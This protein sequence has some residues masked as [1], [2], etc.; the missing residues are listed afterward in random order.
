[1]ETGIVRH[2]STAQQPNSHIKEGNA[3]RPWDIVW[4]YLKHDLIHWKDPWRTF[5]RKKLAKCFFLAL[6]MLILSCS[7]LGLDYQLAY[8]FIHVLVKE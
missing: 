6:I 7:D 5:G 4:V 3:A 1:M 8:Q 2:A